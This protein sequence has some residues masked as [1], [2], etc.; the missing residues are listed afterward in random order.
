M[1]FLFFSGLLL[2]FEQYP[3]A[4]CAFGVL[5]SDSLSLHRSRSLLFTSLLLLFL[6]S[7]LFGGLF[8]QTK[9]LGACCLLGLLL[10]SLSFSLCL[11]F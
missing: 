3:L 4:F 10:E 6:D 9:L 11:R 8:L 2:T 1:R 7:L 5:L